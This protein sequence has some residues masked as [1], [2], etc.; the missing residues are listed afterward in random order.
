MS[1]QEACLAK[2]EADFKQKQSEMTNKIDTLLKALNDRE[3][4]ALPSN[5]VK[6]P[7]LNV[8][9]ISS[10]SSPSSCYNTIRSIHWARVSNKPKPLKK[11]KKLK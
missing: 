1:S 4:G 6:N 8:N 11:T 9:A 10:V 2:F 3:M 7:K 5:T